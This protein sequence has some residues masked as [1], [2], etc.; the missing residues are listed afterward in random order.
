MTLRRLIAPAS[1]LLLAG[2]TDR[3]TFV[4]STDIGIQA[5]V[6]TEQV[7]LGYG[8]TELFQGPA[9]PK[10]GAVPEV[11]GYLGSNLEIFSPK[12]TQVYA[13][14]MAADLATQPV[15]PAQTAEDPDPLGDV[16]EPLVFATESNIGLKLGFT[17]AAP[18]SIKFGYD[19]QEL[20]II[21]LSPEIAKGGT[22]TDGSTKKQYYASVLA[23]MNMDL[24]TPT[25]TATSGSATPTSGVGATSLAVTQF[26]ATGS[27]ARNLA[28]T[29]PIRKQLLKIGSNQVAAAASASTQA[30]V[31]TL[32]SNRNANDSIV[33]SYFTKCAY[34]NAKSPMITALNATGL[35]TQN[36]NTSLNNATNQEEFLNQLNLYGL[37]DTAA[38]KVQG[39]SCSPSS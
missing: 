26:F 24:T 23:T 5:N 27:A 13:T 10:N 33:Q 32:A 29:D 17:S 37:E 1:L 20:S 8:R 12:I 19:R 34:S 35:L 7:H 11:V 14:G 3:A 9:Y 39:L 16:P 22:A 18:T 4:T 6:S 21:P 38:M 2:C 30:L 36:G 25:A 28:K 31:Q 15:A